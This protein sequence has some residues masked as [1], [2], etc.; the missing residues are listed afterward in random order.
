MLAYVTLVSIRLIN[1]NFVDI[2]VLESR[3]L[4][5]RVPVANR[6]CKRHKRVSLL[7]SGYLEQECLKLDEY[8]LYSV[9]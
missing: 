3:Y 1:S 9:G 8:R 4:R 2:P 5:L 7:D 6:L